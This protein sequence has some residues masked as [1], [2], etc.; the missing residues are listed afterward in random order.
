MTRARRTA[1]AAAAATRSG[2]RWSLPRDDAPPR[3]AEWSRSDA[4]SN[5]FAALARALATRRRRQRFWEATTTP[6]TVAAP[7]RYRATR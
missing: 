7:T 1:A 2:A 4:T 6:S 5:L 3:E